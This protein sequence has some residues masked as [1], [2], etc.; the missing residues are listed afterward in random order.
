MAMDYNYFINTRSIIINLLCCI[1]LLSCSNKSKLVPDPASDEEGIYLNASDLRFLP[2]SVRKA[3]DY[4]DRFSL[5]NN[6]F[7]QFTLNN[8]LKV[9]YLLR[10]NLPTISIAVL[11]DAG[12]YQLSAKDE[13][14]SPLV[15]KLLK[16]G[17][18]KYP[19]K[20]FQQRATLLGNPINYWQTAQYSIISAEILAQDFE[21]ALDLLSQQ[22]IS[23][24]PDSDALDVIIEQQLLEN[25]LTQ[26]SGSYLSRLLFYQNNY[27]SSHF[28]Y[29]LQPDSEAI[30][31][32]IKKDLMD[33]YQRKYRPERS[34]IVISGDIDPTLLKKQMESYFSDWKNNHT[35]IKSTALFDNQLPEM[36]QSRF[37]FIER[38]GAQQVDLLYG[39]ITAARR[40][41]DWPGLKII[42]ALIGGGSNS[43]LFADLREKQ[44]LAY[45]ISARQLAGRYSSPFLIQTSVAH[46]KLIPAIKGITN[47]LNYLCLNKI[48][49]HEL[50]QIKQQLS[51]EIVFKLQTNQQRISNKILQLETNL[52]DNYLFNLKRQINNTT[53]EQLFVIA[54]K[55]LCG[56]RNI[57][58]V[59]QKNQLENNFRNNLKGYFYEEH[60]L[61]L[62]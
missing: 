55:Y 10:K 48:E 1:L 49:K 62:H 56:K 32:V 33:F 3:E 46:N 37:D 51:G 12:K 24:E 11:V 42:A 15:I 16:Q 29:H 6:Q 2:E 22:L 38:E 57:I 61:P 17:T 13:R 40:S 41:P 34:Q 20:N 18:K 8:G 26:S 58:A 47:H 60:H 25:K 45:Y 14:L 30:K 53:A 59:G 27:P 52:D 54:N 4:S 5:P 35:E 44:G 9:N 19:K 28:Y 7:M 31:K 23:I 36:K 39:V 43:R 50:E 21:L